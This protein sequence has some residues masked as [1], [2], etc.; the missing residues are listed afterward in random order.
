MLRCCA[1]TLTLSALQTP[2]NRALCRLIQAPAAVCTTI[3]DSMHEVAPPPLH[4][5]HPP[6]PSPPPHTHNPPPCRPKFEPPESEGAGPGLPPP[7]LVTRK[8][9]GQVLPPSNPNI[10]HQGKENPHP[11]AKGER[12]PGAEHGRRRKERGEAAEQR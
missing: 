2:G 5:P 12:A 11:A 6:T 4:P 7:P 8:Q 1:P 10:H 3:K 9:G